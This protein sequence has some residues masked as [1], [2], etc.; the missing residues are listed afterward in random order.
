[1]LGSIKQLRD[2]AA[3]AECPWPR[4]ELRQ[5]TA[6]R[7]CQV[8]LFAGRPGKQI[9]A[10][11][12]AHSGEAEIVGCSARHRPAMA[13]DRTIRCIVWFRLTRSTG[14]AIRSV[15][16]ANNIVDASLING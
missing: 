1:V 7:S 9:S 12:K 10:G 8:C 13:S 5:Q 6:L 15:A 11:L 14:A 3:R 4:H 2:F 16:P